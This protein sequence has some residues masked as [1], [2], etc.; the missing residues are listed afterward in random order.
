MDS[1]KNSLSRPDSYL[2]HLLD[3]YFQA[4]LWY[5]I[6]GFIKLLFL[7]LFG[8]RNVWCMERALLEKH[9]FWNS[10]GAERDTGRRDVSFMAGTMRK[11][12]L[13]EFRKSLGAECNMTALAVCIGNSNDFGYSANNFEQSGN[14][15]R[16]YCY[17]FYVIAV[18]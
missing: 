17:G 6:Y 4:R 11:S 1:I 16:S 14:Y 5:D 18:S 9:E 12:P 7:C 3:Y 8:A 2:H 13:K 15:R 10:Q